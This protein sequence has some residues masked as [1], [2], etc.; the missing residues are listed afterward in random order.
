[1]WECCSLPSLASAHAPGLETATCRWLNSRKMVLIP[2]PLPGAR[3]ALCK[4]DLI[5]FAL[6]ARLSQL[7]PC[8]Y[9]GQIFLCWGPV[10]CTRKLSNISGLPS[11]GPRSIPSSIIDV[12]RHRH[13]SPPRVG[14]KSPRIKNLSALH[15]LCC[16]SVPQSCPT[17]CDPVDCSAPGLPICHYLPELAQSHV[18]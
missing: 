9:Q 8:W 4:R 5:M 2:E 13:V 3:P 17:L 12:S 6:Y 11:L 16:C 1:M 7:Q 10:L 18:R 15:H 14:A